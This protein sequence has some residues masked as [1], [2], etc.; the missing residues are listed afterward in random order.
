MDKDYSMGLYGFGAFSVFMWIVFLAIYILQATAMFK[1]YQKAN[2]KHA[3]LAYIPIAQLWPFFWA[4]KKSA[5]NILWFLL[6]IAGIVIGV[7]ILAVW[8]DTPAFVIY[9]SISFWF[10]YLRLFQLYCILS[11]WYDYSKLIT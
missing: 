9:R 1:M 2:I 11:G 3:W 7:I 4:I 8:Q 10:L 6:P 5:W